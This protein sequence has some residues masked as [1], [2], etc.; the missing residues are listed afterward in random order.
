LADLDDKEHIE[1]RHITEAL[2]Y[3]GMD[4]RAG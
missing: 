3:R 2:A 4:R 1:I